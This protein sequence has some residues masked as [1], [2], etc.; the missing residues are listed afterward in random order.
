MTDKTALKG[1]TLKKLVFPNPYYQPETSAE[2][3]ERQRKAR[4]L[5]REAAKKQITEIKRLRAAKNKLNLKGADMLTMKVIQNLSERDRQKFL[6]EVNNED[7][8]LAVQ[9]ENETLV[10]SLATVMS[11]RCGE[12][13][14]VLVKKAAEQLAQEEAEAEK[15]DE[16]GELTEEEAPASVTAAREKMF[17]VVTKLAEDGD[18]E[19][20]EILLPGI[21]VDFKEWLAQMQSQV[22][23]RIEEVQYGRALLRK[24]ILSEAENL[25]EEKRRQISDEI[26]GNWGNED[27]IARIEDIFKT[28]FEDFINGF[29]EKQ[30][31]ADGR[32]DSARKAILALGD[33]ARRKI[34]ANLILEREDKIR[35]T[36]EK[37]FINF[38][39]LL[40]IPD[41]GIQKFLREVDGETLAKALKPARVE[42]QEKIFCNMSKRAAAMLKEDIAYMGPLR[43]KDAYEA[44]NEVIA[45]LDR[46]EKSGEI[47]I[48][49]P[50][51]EE[52]FV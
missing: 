38:D 13:F 19:I 25:G 31:L 17:A 8:A 34:L 26:L 5:R 49:R 11:K 24:R 15:S 42:V 23:E 33:T 40:L 36:L 21:S 51:E 37:D 32:C 48:A 44:Q 14:R 27:D 4:E 41:I 20:P 9:G 12:E 50:G 10:D 3:L 22:C 46:L 16:D 43:K 29:F 45:I 18:I 39:D 30:L 35:R 2:E 7:L 28:E 47:V 6:R 52:D 1:L